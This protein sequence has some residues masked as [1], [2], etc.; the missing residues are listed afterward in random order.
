MTDETSA[1]AKDSKADEEEKSAP[2]KKFQPKND[3]D[4]VVSLILRLP[5]RDQE[6]FIF[7]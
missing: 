7:R 5:W 4:S 6:D 2:P 1:D 3:L